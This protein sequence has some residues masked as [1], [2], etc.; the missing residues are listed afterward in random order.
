MSI[1]WFSWIFWSVFGSVVFWIFFSVRSSTP[2]TAHLSTGRRIARRLNARTGEFV[3]SSNAS[4]FSI[5]PGSFRRKSLASCCCS[6]AAILFKNHLKE[7]I[8]VF[9][10]RERE[11]LESARWRSGW[12][13]F[14]VLLL[15]SQLKHFTSGRQSLVGAVQAEQL[16]AKF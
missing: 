9:R 3:D 4:S 15:S 10:E 16:M 6:M 13:R 14:V 11:R 7:W 8:R 12:A 1:L 2:G 5:I